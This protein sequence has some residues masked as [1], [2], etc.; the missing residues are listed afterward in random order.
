MGGSAFAVQDQELDR[1]L[2]LSLQDLL[3]VEVSS[4]SRKSESI[5]KSAAAVYVVTADD[6]RRSG[7]ASIPEALRLVPGVNVAR[8]NSNQWAVGIRGFMGRFNDKLLVQMDGRTVYRPSFSGTYWEELDTYLPDIER[9]E[10]IRGPGATLWGSNAV[11]GI[12]NIVTRSS[13][14]TRG[15]QVSAGV[16]TDTEALLGVRHG[17]KLT[18]NID[19]RFYL[20]TRQQ[21]A[22]TLYPSEG[23]AEDESGIVS[24]GFRTD[25]QLNSETHWTL[26]ADTYRFE[27]DFLDQLTVPSTRQTTESNGWNILGRIE[28]GT[29]NNG[30][31]RLQTYLAH[32]DRDDPFLGQI[33]DT[34]DIDFQHRFPL[35]SAQEI[36]WG[37]GYRYIDDEYRNTALVSMNPDNADG[38]IFNAFVQDEIQLIPDQLKLVVGTKFEDHYFTGSSW[39]PSAR[40]WWSPHTDHALWGSI[41]SAVR[42]PSRY[43]RGI[44]V[45]NLQLMNTVFGNPSQK[46][47]ELLAYELGYRF[48]ARADLSI[49]L[50]FFY[51]DYD[52]IQSSEPA[53]PPPNARFDNLR[54]GDAVGGEVFVEWTPRSDTR[55]RFG[56][57]YLDLDIAYVPP[58]LV[59]GQGLDRTYTEGTPGHTVSLQWSHDLNERWDWDIWALYTDEIGQP[60]A[61][62]FSPSIDAALNLGGR[63]AWRPK[64]GLELSLTGQN[65]LESDRLEYTAEFFT[66]YS[67]VPRSLLLRARWDIE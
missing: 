3:S 23:D 4:V 28:G 57:A 42:I 50:A 29:A 8:I 62:P 59:T 35:L 58:S 13:V 49:D 41:S 9:I 63:V 12:I 21:D 16:G 32:T 61:A 37:L 1:M 39:Q 33:E 65:L 36:V 51:N 26:Q 38:E 27:A 67:E 64:A 10:V 44:R 14:E 2:T 47:E 15:T 7:A 60:G 30:Q 48:G 53:F 6:I 46:N 17:A 34:F 40:A 11:N 22:V 54:A 19:G 31:W 20:N 43:E 66:P 24:G 52:H 55:L 5:R 25:G 45:S 56:Y 18:D